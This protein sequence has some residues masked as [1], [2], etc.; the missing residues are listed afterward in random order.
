MKF[1]RGNRSTQHRQPWDDLAVVPWFAELS[2]AQ[3]RAASRH[4]DWVPVRAGQ[5]LQRQSFH[6][7]WLWI[8]VDGTLELRRNDAWV[9]VVEPGGAWGEAEALLGL[10]SSVDVL[11]GED[12]T[13]LSLPANAFHGMLGDAAFAATMARRQAKAWLGPQPARATST[14][15]VSPAA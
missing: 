14:A 7:R 3:R 12:A 6:V 10:P 15:S 11:V 13:V 9:G 8:P 4:T 5:R 2:A 1:A